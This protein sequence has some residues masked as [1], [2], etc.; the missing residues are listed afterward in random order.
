MLLAGVLIG[1][2]GGVL[3]LNAAGL[4]D[5]LAAMA[6]IWPV[7]LRGWAGDNPLNYRLVGAAFVILGLVMAGRG[8]SLW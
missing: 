8:L 7:W 1:I 4:A 5:G 6:R 3:A 2:V